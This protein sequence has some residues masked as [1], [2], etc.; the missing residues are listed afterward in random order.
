M[1]QRRDTSRI[2]RRIIFGLWICLAL[3]TNP[4]AIAQSG[5]QF[6]SLLEADKTVEL[7]TRTMGIVSAVTL[8]EGGRVSEG[9]ILLQLNDDDVLAQT[10]QAESRY[11]FAQKSFEWDER[12]FQQEAISERQYLESKT[13]LIDA[14]TALHNARSALEK[15]RVVAPFSGVTVNPEQPVVVGQLLPPNAPVCTLIKFNPLKAV[16]YIPEPNIQNIA[17]GTRAVVQS[18]HHQHLQAN[19]VVVEKSPIIDPASGTNK[20]KLAIQGNAAGFLPGM[21]V[22]VSFSSPAQ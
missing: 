21:Q 8:R 5:Q 3:G 17:M 6:E 1:A 7:T 4:L 12:L 16:I 11:E 14:E 22:T 2:N 13:R 20:V 18:R 9:D 10:K 15:T 19:A